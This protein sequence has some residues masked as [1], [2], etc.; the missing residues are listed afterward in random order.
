MAGRHHGCNEHELGQTLGRG[1]GQG[2][3]VWGHKESDTTGQLNNNKQYHPVRWETGD[4]C[5]MSSRTRM[6]H[7]SGEA[8]P[9]ARYLVARNPEQ[10][11]R[12]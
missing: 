7:K 8:A 10:E 6:E 5:S 4:W 9:V 3:L 12:I 1:E 2:S 11:A